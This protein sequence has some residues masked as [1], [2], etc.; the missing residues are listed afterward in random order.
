MQSR[1]ESIVEFECNLRE[2]YVRQKEK[3]NS[4]FIHIY[5]NA[6]EEDRKTVQLKRTQTE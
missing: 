3:Q 4:R 5:R 2:S 6:I 1:V